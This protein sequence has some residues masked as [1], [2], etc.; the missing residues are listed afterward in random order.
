MNSQQGCESPCCFNIVIF[1]QNDYIE[2]TDDYI[3]KNN[4]KSQGFVEVDG[5]KRCWF[6]EFSLY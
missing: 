1:D 3:E 5:Q 4:S 6:R 2:E